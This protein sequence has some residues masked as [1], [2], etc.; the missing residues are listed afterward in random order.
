VS[1]LDA[2]LAWDRRVVSVLLERGADVVTDY[3][4]ASASNVDEHR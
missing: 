4:T 1:F 3:A 2:L